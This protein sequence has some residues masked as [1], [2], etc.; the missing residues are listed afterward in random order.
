[1]DKIKKWALLT[2]FIV[3][4]ANV[5]AQGSVE[6]PSQTPSQ[7]TVRCTPTPAPEKPTPPRDHRTCIPKPKTPKS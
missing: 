2:L 3:A 6:K 7:T 4:S 5:F 1:M